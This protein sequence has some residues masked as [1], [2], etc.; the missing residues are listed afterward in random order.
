MEETSVIIGGNWNGLRGR[1]DEAKDV[2]CLP[3]GAAWF[4]SDGLWLK[5]DQELDALSAVS[6]RKVKHQSRKC[7]VSDST[8]RCG[9]EWCGLFWRRQADGRQR[10][11]VTAGSAAIVSTVESDSC[12]RLSHNKQLKS[13]SHHCQIWRLNTCSGFL[14]SLGISKCV[15]VFAIRISQTFLIIIEVNLN[16]YPERYIKESNVPLSLP[17]S[18]CLCLLFGVWGFY[19]VLYTLRLN[20][21][22][23][24][25]QYDQ[26][27]E[28]EGG[29]NIKMTSNYQ[30]IAIRLSV[31]YI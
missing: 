2:S 9:R 7:R 20:Q 11:E 27:N 4:H 13:I 10:S 26:N 12:C 14:I 16:L 15:G 18:L 8:A 19:R 1:P 6:C 21:A 5:A 31:C 29:W 28:L 30:N 3:R 25:L 22:L 23:N 17:D 24:V